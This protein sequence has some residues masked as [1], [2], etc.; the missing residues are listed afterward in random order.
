MRPVDEQGVEVRRPDGKDENDGRRSPEAATM[1][2]DS[3]P[4]S[5]PISP[6]DAPKSHLLVANVAYS[7]RASIDRVIASGKVDDTARV[8]RIEEPPYEQ[9]SEASSRVGI[10]HVPGTD[11]ESDVEGGIDD[12]SSVTRVSPRAMSR[13]PTRFDTSLTTPPCLVKVL[14]RTPMS[15]VAKVL[16]L[17][18]A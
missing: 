13:K 2:L 9:A 17:T 10:H 15:S 18:P 11:E 7:Q 12:M 14:K 6:R 1:G 5:R 8:S 16:K 3:T 4:D